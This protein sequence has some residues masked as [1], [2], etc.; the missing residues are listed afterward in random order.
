MFK[1]CSG[2]E[3]STLKINPLLGVET[4]APSYKNEIGIY[5]KSN[6]G[7]SPKRANI[8]LDGFSILPL[9]EPYSLDL[10]E[11]LSLQGVN[12]DRGSSFGGNRLEATLPEL[13]AALRKALF[14]KVTA[15]IADRLSEQFARKAEAITLDDLT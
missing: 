5:R 3:F 6:S 11:K 9:F 10:K 2:R 15:Q 7:R 14:D 4:I 8:A 1:S 12:T 13:D